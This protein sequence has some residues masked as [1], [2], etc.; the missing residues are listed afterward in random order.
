MTRLSRPVGPADHAQGPPDA[1]VTLV[2]YGDFECPHCGRAYPIVKAVQGRMGDRLRFVYRHFPLTQAHPH[3]QHAAEMA[4][5]AAEGAKFWEMHDALFENQFALEDEDLL[6]YAAE[7]SLDETRAAA[8]LAEHTFAERVRRDFMSGVRSGVNGTPTFF[9]NGVRD[10]SG[11][12]EDVD[13][14][15]ELLESAALAPRS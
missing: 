3:A 4:E 5:A 11:V 2:E 13:A 9:I 10:D 7:L 6:T 12:W 8:A 14:F 15:V 1:P